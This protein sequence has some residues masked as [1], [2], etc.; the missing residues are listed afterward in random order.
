MFLKIVEETKEI[1]P[2]DLHSY[3]L[4]TNH[5]H[6]AVETKNVEVW[7]IMNRISKKYC[8]YYNK[9]Y[10]LVGHLFQGRY[11]APIIDDLAYLLQTSRYIHRNPVKANIVSKPQDYEW[12]SYRAYLGLE[13]NKLVTTQKILKEFVYSKITNY[14]EY[15]EGAL[16]LDNTST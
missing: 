9:K 16:C 14:Q 10:G 1:H 15:V 11:N 8:N 3:C 13:N 4:M 6:L 7:H 2:F 5:F 12:S